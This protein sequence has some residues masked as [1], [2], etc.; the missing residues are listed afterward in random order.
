MRERLMNLANLCP[1]D[2]GAD[3][4]IIDSFTGCCHHSQKK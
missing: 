4:P 1:G 3:C 2:D